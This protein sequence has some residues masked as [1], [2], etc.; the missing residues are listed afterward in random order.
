VSRPVG[1][2]RLIVKVNGL[3]PLLGRGARDL[4]RIARAVESWGADG[5]VLGQHLF[6][7]SQVNHPGA[8]QLDPGRTSLDPMLTLA[9]ISASTTHV[10]LM[11]GAVI[12]PLQSAVGLGKAA[13]TLDQLSGGRLE[14]GVVPGWQESEFHAAGVPF[15]ER[16]A[17][18]DEAISVWRTMWAGSPFS[19]RGRWTTVADVW[20]RPE[21]LQGAALPVLIGGGPS[22]AMAR[23]AVRLGDGWIAS[24]AAGPDEVAR[25]VGLIEQQCRELGRECAG[26]RTRATISSKDL[27]SD[28]AGELARRAR[29]LLRAGADDV[30]LSLAGAADGPA[31]AEDLVRTLAAA[32]LT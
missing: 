30:A 4:P 14:L 17:R 9:A 16:F 6:Y 3:L 19:Y 1:R 7:E 21:P 8:V 18:L 31:Q 27:G 25:G 23:R 26:F 12:A 20:S 2:P 10:R 32:I 29:R 24:E 13:A 15:D 5:L 22:K 28:S 11:T